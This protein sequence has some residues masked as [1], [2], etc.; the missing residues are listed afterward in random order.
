MIDSDFNIQNF[1]NFRD[2]EEARRPEMACQHYLR[3]KKGM[4]DPFNVPANIEVAERYG[5]SCILANRYPDKTLFSHLWSHPTELAGMKL[6]TG[7]ALFYLFRKK[8]ILLLLI[9]ILST[10][11]FNLYS[12]VNGDQCKITQ[13]CADNWISKLSLGK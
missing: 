2:D 11:F 6:G 5:R 13:N 3:K 8:M 7:F 12:N 9:L 1:V 4:S 10:G